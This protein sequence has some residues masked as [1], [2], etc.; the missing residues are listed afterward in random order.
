MLLYMLADRIFLW[1]NWGTERGSLQEARHVR[2]HPC[3][4]TGVSADRGVRGQ[5]CLLAG[6]FV[7]NKY[8]L[9]VI[10]IKT[11]YC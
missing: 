2:G 5:G 3:P 9:I 6:T 4:R 1:W 8:Q 10:R 11:I 7:E